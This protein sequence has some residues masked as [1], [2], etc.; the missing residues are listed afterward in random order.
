MNM[1]PRKRKARAAKRKS[2]EVRLRR[3]AYIAK[4]VQNVHEIAIK[5]FDLPDEYYSW[6]Y[7][8]H[9]RRYMKSFRPG[10]EFDL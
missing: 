3:V 9:V 1:S 2:K 10:A 6:T 7:E 4:H 5:L 8:Q